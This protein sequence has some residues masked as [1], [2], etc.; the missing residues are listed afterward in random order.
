MQR[1]KRELLETFLHLHTFLHDLSIEKMVIKVFDT[2][3][4]TRR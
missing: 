4:F 1:D 2:E 3:K